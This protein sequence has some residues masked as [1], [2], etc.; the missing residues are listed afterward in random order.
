MGVVVG[1][2]FR[3][4]AGSTEHHRVGM[5]TGKHF[6]SAVIIFISVNSPPYFAILLLSSNFS[7]KQLLDKDAQDPNDDGSSVGSVGS[8]SSSS[9]KESVQQQT[10]RSRSKSTSRRSRHRSPLSERNHNHEN[11]RA[12]KQQRRLNNS[13]DAM[14]K[15]RR[16]STTSASATT[17]DKSKTNKSSASKQQEKD[18]LDQLQAL[19]KEKEEQAKKSEAKDA[20][21]AALEAKFEAFKKKRKRNELPDGDIPVVAKND[22]ITK[23]VVDGVTRHLWRDCKFIGTPKQI[24][25]AL[26]VIL[27]NSTEWKKF[28]K[29]DKKEREAKIQGYANTYGSKITHTLNE[30][31]SSVQTGIRS[32][33]MERVKKGDKVPTA[34]QFLQIV[35]REGLEQ[36]KVPVLSEEDKKDKAKVAELAAIKKKN[37][38]IKDNQNWFAW[39]HDKILAKVGGRPFWPESVRHYQTI[40][41]AT[42]PDDDS[43]LYITPSTEAFAVLC[44]ENNKTKWPYEAK[45]GDDPKNEAMETQYTC[46]KSGQNKFGGWNNAGRK[47]LVELVDKIKAARAD[48]KSEKAELMVLDH[49][50]TEH[51]IAEK[52]AKKKAKKKAKRDMDSEV[53]EIPFDEEMEEEDEDEGSSTEGDVEEEEDD[54]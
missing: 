43:K 30:K 28:E 51:K 36:I 5:S 3:G 47:R 49:L 27:K 52:E 46:S 18:L 33:Y 32:L 26:K 25:S 16:N 34:E 12:S 4:D 20:Q 2:I 21:L 9:S 23:L 53:V 8:Q 41:G 7:S 15:T 14:A 6:V 42:F 1:L 24:T 37:A 19:E 10:R 35:L 31:R 48:P 22:A 17:G 45:K 54:E 40:S 50:Q 39:Y 13:Q 44:F 38:Q 29:L 11:L